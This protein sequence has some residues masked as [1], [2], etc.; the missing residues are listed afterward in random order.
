MCLH[1]YAYIYTCIYVYR[2]IYVHIPGPGLRKMKACLTM[3]RVTGP[4]I[5]VLVVSRPRYMHMYL[6]TL[7]LSS[8]HVFRCQGHGSVATPRSRTESV[9]SIYRPQLGPHVLKGATWTNKNVCKAHS[10]SSCFK[11]ILAF[12][13][14][15]AAHLRQ[16]AFVSHISRTL[17]LQKA[18]S[19]NVATWI[20]KVGKIAAFRAVCIGLCAILLHTFGV[21]VG[22]PVLL[23]VALHWRF[24]CFSSPTLA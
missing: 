9:S 8:T 17:K 21:Q 1:I 14:S 2:C 20:P 7:V 23:R 24:K 3:F 19:M 13:S 11:I 4:L 10:L 15:I 6:Q 12:C 5:Y 16:L 18:A 22:C